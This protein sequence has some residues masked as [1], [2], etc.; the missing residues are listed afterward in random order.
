MYSHTNFGK[1]IIRF[2]TPLCPIR[3]LRTLDSE[4][5]PEQILSMVVLQVDDDIR[6]HCERNQQTIFEIRNFV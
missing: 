3:V 4:N 2:Q 6:Q 5:N 1:A